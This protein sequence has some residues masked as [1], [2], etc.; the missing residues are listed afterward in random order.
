M[1]LVSL[2]G[3]ATSSWPGCSGAPT[4]CSAGT[5]QASSPIAA[6]TSVPMR[7]MMRIE[8]TTYGLSVS[9]TP[10]IACGASSGPMQNGMTYIVRPRMHPR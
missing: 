9:S 8:A 6:S 1:N 7:V 5:N 10:N 2:Q 4:E 3:Q